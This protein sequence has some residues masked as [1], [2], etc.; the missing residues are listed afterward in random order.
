MLPVEAQ[1]YK[2]NEMINQVRKEMSEQVKNEVILS[3][4]NESIKSRVMVFGVIS[5]V[6]MGA[7]TFLQVKYLKNF[8]RHK[9]II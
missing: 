1:A 6:I 7:S 4:H 5:M 9:K 3:D 8:F 2:I